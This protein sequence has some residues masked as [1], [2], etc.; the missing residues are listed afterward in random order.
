MSE[1]DPE[2]LID[3]ITF[4]RIKEIQRDTDIESHAHIIL[5]AVKLLHS[6]VSLQRAG[7]VIYAHAKGQSPRRL[8]FGFKLKGDPTLS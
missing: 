1:K 6:L 2:I 7:S 8:A 5:I 3:R 4:D